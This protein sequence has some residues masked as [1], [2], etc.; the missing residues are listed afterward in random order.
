MALFA[1]ASIWHIMPPLSLARELLSGMAVSPCSLCSYLDDEA[2]EP[3]KR[4]D[5]PRD[6]VCLVY[7]SAAS[8][9]SPVLGSVKGTTENLQAAANS[10]AFEF[11]QMYPKFLAEAEDD[12]DAVH[13]TEPARFGRRKVSWSNVLPSEPCYRLE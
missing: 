13:R 4:A 10:Q 8:E 2:A 12:L 11:T 7:G 3:T 1:C 6:A 5:P 9:F